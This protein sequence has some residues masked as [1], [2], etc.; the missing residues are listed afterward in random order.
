[1]FNGTDANNGVKPQYD[2]FGRVTNG[3][4][5]TGNYKKYRDEERALNKQAEADHPMLYKGSEIG[6]GVVSGLLAPGASTLSGAIGYGSLQGLGAVTLMT[7]ASLSRI[8]Q[9]VVPSVLQVTAQEKLL[10][11]SPRLQTG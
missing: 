1:L 4:E 7:L 9:S 8:L 10:S 5:L 11:K 2:E 3:Q 6:G